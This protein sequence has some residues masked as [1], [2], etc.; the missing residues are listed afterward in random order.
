MRK[1]YAKMFVEA[2]WEINR[3]EAKWS[4]T[5]L[6]I[7]APSA[8]AGKLVALQMEC[9]SHGL[10]E[11]AK[12]CDR[13]MND[14]RSRPVTYR[15]IVGALKELR[16]RLEDELESEL[17]LHLSPQEAEMYEKPV[18][19]W[20]T[21]IARFPRIRTD[22]EDSSKCFAFGMYAAAVFHI[23]L[24]AEFGVIELAKLVGS[25][26]NKPGWASLGKV[27][28]I[29]TVPFLQRTALEQQHSELLKNTAPLTHAI[30]EAWRHK[31]SHADNKLEWIDTDFS[32]RTANEIITATR[33]FMRRLATDLPQQV[34]E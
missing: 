13:I 20:N 21:A 9:V 31:I 17:F 5:D 14:C 32:P 19:D 3:L 6:V 34:L 28:K 18:K 29:L 33:G 23:L 4:P 12:K 11:T 24:V 7:P 10:T 16:E 25:A 30:K 1:L 26:G 22:V 8:V 2:L 15:E 27:E